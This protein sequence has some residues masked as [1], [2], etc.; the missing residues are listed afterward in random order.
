MKISDQRMDSVS[1]VILTPVVL[2]RFPVIR[3]GV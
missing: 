3:V 2:P 1:D